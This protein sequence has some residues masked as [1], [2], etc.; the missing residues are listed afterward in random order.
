[1]NRLKVKANTAFNYVFAL[2]FGIITV[3]VVVVLFKNI[4]VILFALAA[5][6]VFTAAGTYIYTN[7]KTPTAKQADIACI[8]ILAVMFILQLISGW[9]LMSKPITDWGTVDHMAHNFATDGNFDDM[10]RGLKPASRGY[11]A[12]YPN[13]NG[14]LILLSLYYRAIYL[15]MGDVPN[16]APILLNTV[17]IAVAVLFTFLT[18]RKIFKPYGVI[19]TVVFCF[20]FMPYYTY[21]AYYYS[22]SLSIPFTVMSVY[23]I[24]LS[25]KLPKERLVQRL[26]YLALSALFISVGYTIKGSLLVILVGA[27]VYLVLYNKLKQALISILRLVV[28]FAVFNTGIKTFINSFEFTTKEELYEEQFPINHWIMMGLYGDGGFHQEDAVYT[29]NAGNYDQKKAADNKMIV[30]R[31]KDMGLPGM[32]KHMCNKLTFTW[33]DGIYWV[34]HHLNSKDADGNQIADRNPLFEFVLRDG[35]YYNIFYVYSNGFHLAMIILMAVSAIYGA[36]RKRITSMTLIRGI[37][38]GAALFFMVWETRSRY[39]FNFTP[40]FIL[41]AVAGLNSVVLRIQVYKRNKR[42][43]LAAKQKEKSAAAAKES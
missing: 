37:V 3:L 10:Y 8:I 4:F 1:M 16:Y 38:F 13:N 39:L 30:K 27:V 32:A 29:N 34:D 25:A 2:L 26:I 14:I 43:K 17:F 41:T 21:T 33:R 23:F 22:D 7:K 18:A 20:L 40:L 6:F 24:V 19:M 36:K 28:A 42:K 11:M 9:C 5:L 31:L 12:R 15:I 35:D